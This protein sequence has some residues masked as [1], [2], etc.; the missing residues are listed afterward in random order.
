MPAK[1]KIGRKPK[2]VGMELKSV[3]DRDNGCIL[4]LE[5]HEGKQKQQLK[6]FE[7]HGLCRS[8]FGTGRT[9]VCRLCI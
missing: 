8:W 7:V 4:C 6:E 9:V 2:G 5:M 3:A 1:T